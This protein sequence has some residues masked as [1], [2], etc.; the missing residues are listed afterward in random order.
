M[1][2][3]EHL[4]ACLICAQQVLT[5]WR[6]L[7]HQV[8]IGA[9]HAEAWLLGYFGVQRVS[10]QDPSTTTQFYTIFMFTPYSCFAERD[11][12]VSSAPGGYGQSMKF[13]ETY[14]SAG[15][16]A[17]VEN[18]LDLEVCEGLLMLHRG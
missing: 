10:A 2:F 12:P 11:C 5:R 7:G 15:Y 8:H 6:R 4:V 14:I 9:A 16:I 3:E 13:H 1:R 17:S 18:D